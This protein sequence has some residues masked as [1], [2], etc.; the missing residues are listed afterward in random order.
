MN[1]DGFILIVFSVL[2][3]EILLEQ[4]SWKITDFPNNSWI[5]QYRCRFHFD[6]I[7]LLYSMWLYINYF[8]MKYDFMILAENDN[9]IL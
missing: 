4:F 2:L 5:E 1:S 3:M 6:F 9:I 8:L 7:V